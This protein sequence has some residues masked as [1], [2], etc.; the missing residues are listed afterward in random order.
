M[1]K[2]INCQISN[3]MNRLYFVL[4]IFKYLKQKNYLQI[5]FGGRCVLVNH[6]SV[7]DFV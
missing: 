1:K 3:D 5:A 7:K 4:K 2:Q 6:S